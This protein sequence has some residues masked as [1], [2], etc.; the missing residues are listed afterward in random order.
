MPFSGFQDFRP[1]FGT[2]MQ[3][4]IAANPGISINSGY[5][6]PEHQ[7]ELYQAA[8]QKYGPDRAGHYVGKPGG[9]YHNKRLAADL[10]YKDDAARQW[11]HTN[12]A[13]YGLAFPLGHEDWHVELAGARNGGAG[14]APADP[15]D[16]SVGDTA[17]VLANATDPNKPLYDLSSLAAGAAKRQSELG[18]PVKIR[19]TPRRPETPLLEVPLVSALDNQVETRNNVSPLSPLSPLADLFQVKAIGQAGTPKIPGRRF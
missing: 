7:A 16:N 2:A 10:G 17:S 19:E 18:G 6:T 1:D 9:S 4:F 5:R 12:A 8:V 3:R 13:A 15:S 11:A 14:T